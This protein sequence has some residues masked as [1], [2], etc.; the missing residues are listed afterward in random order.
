MNRSRGLMLALLLAVIPAYADEAEYGAIEIRS[1]PER[2]SVYIEG[3]F[4][5]TTPT[6]VPDVPEGSYRVVV[7]SE[8]LGDY[9]EDIVVEKLKTTTVSATFSEG[10][11]RSPVRA[12]KDYDSV[13]GKEARKPY[14][15]AKSVKKLRDYGVLEIASFL[16]KSEE[17]LAPESLYSIFHDLAEQ[18]DEKTKFDT[19]VTNYTQGPSA[20]WKESASP[21]PPTLVLSGVITEYEAGSKTKRYLVGFGAGK[22]RAYCL[23]R[24]ID[25]ATGEV[26]LERMENGSVSMGLFGGSSSGAMKEIGEDIAKA[27]RKNW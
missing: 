6:S 5:G 27:I 3:F 1:E 23:F 26:V 12:D 16:M 4:S 17:P 22:T 14:E 25:K 15:Q 19:F 2:A 13:V 20:R 7:K 18:L 9:V 24:L 8:I 21:E 10:G 11:Y